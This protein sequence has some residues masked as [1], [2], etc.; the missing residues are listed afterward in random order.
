[1]KWF[2]VFLAFFSLATPAVSF[3]P[4]EKLQDAVLETRA[5]ALFP[6]LRC[7]VC[8]NQSI[9]DSDATLARDLRLLVRERLVLGDSDSQIVD[10]LVA[11]YGE[12]ILLRPRFGLHTYALWGFTP[13]VMI[14]GAG[15][16]IMRSR[17]KDKKHPDIDPSGSLMTKAEQNILNSLQEDNAT[18]K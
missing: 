10:Y 11:R 12:F 15:I 17:R 14:L 9:A 8:Q 5:K 16:L 1:M 7:L 18:K 2:L 6:E 3:D 13:F 4:G